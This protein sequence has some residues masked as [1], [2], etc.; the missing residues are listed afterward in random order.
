MIAATIRYPLISREHLSSSIM[1]TGYR[2][3]GSPLGFEW[4]EIGAIFLKELENLFNAILGPGRSYLRMMVHIANKE[5]RPTI[6]FEFKLVPIAP[7]D[8][9]FLDYEWSGQH[10]PFH[11]FD[12]LYDIGDGN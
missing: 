2:L 6:A 7:Y 1:L 11:R 12:W 10:D 3:F 4:P 9:F 8:F 5:Q